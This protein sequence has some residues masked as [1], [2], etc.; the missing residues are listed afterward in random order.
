MERSETWSPYIEIDRSGNKI[1]RR[2]SGISDLIISDLLLRL[3]R[4]EPKEFW[5]LTYFNREPRIPWHGRYLSPLSCDDCACPG[6]P[7][8]DMGAC[9]RS[10]QTSTFIFPTYLLI[11]LWY[12]DPCEYRKPQFRTEAQEPRN[13]VNWLSGGNGF[14]KL[15]DH[16]QRRSRIL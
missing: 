1:R 4:P 14:C 16:G 11:L 6:H 8:W 13:E 5:L 3:V 15:F 12:G 2:C 7:P 10:A 9:R